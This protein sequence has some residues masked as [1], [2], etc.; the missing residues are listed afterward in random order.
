MNGKSYFAS[1][2]L[3]GEYARSLW[4]RVRDYYVFLS[5]S[6]FID[7]Y[8]LIHSQMFRGLYNIGNVERYGVDQ[9]KRKVDVNRFRKNINTRF[10]IITQN[11]PQL[12][13]RAKTSDYNGIKKAK[14]GNLFL[15]NVNR[16]NRNEETL[17]DTAMT[18]TAY[19]EAWTLTKNYPQDGYSKS[20][21]CDHSIYPWDVVRDV[22]AKR[23]EDCNWFIV[24]ETKSRHE[25]M[26]EYPEYAT[27]I[28]IVND[29]VGGLESGNFWQG[30]WLTSLQRAY[31][32]DKEWLTGYTLYH[33]KTEL[34]PSGRK[35]VFFND[36][37]IVSDEKLDIFPLQY[38]F[39]DQVDGVPLGYGDFDALVLQKIY[40]AIH[41][42]IVTRQ[43]LLGSPSILAEDSSALDVE[44]LMDGFKWFKYTRGMQKPEVLDFLKTPAELFNYA[45]TIGMLMDQMQG[46][47]DVDNGMLPE[48]KSVS[49]VV[50]NS[51]DTKSVRY[52]SAFQVNYARYLEE[53]SRT[54]LKLWCASGEEDYKVKVLGKN[55][56][57][58]A[59]SISREWLSDIDGFDAE[60]V[61][62]IFN[63]DQ[64]R[65]QLLDI[66]GKYNLIKQTQDIEN[67]LETG[68]IEVM[69]DK[70]ES[71]TNYYENIREQLMDGVL[72]VS[73]VTDNH[74]ELT[75]IA[76][77][78]LNTDNVKN[79]PELLQAIH[80]FYQAEDMK[81]GAMTPSELMLHGAPPKPMP[82]PPMPPAPPSVTP[83]SPMGV[84]TPPLPP[85][86][87]SV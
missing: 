4:S 36:S 64:G 51:L 19:G 41:S 73:R 60:L 67:I 47:S 40:S 7:L 30:W 8:S 62:P 22:T 57:Y 20:G 66:Y 25:W 49:G 87:A 80:G 58:L 86:G 13:A 56:K 14:A 48:G 24:R 35:T 85:M 76:L 28:E 29:G 33:K 55:N 38:L 10:V 72:P 18:A 17:L 42:A 75:R 69:T 59:P 1:Q 77:D 32:S 79:N 43:V 78:V 65:M 2:E 6:G 12:K 15:A 37:L 82:L 68:R 9:N 46:L 23:I 34:L 45:Q 39:A 74:F 31:D 11:R 83:P 26:R 71:K 53:N 27:Q 44:S 3:G 61:N 70:I 84:P 54:K 81:W 52:N 63:T 5:G 50:I 21:V 16:E